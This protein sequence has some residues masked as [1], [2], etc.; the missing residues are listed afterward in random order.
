MTTP[1]VDYTF[2]TGNEYKGN[3]VASADFPRIALRASAIID[4]ITFNRSLPVIE[5]DEDDDTILA[6]QLATCAV[7]DVLGQAELIGGKGEIV[8][9]RVGN[10]SNSYAQT[11]TSK[12]SPQ[13]QQVNAARTY[14]EKTGLMFKGLEATE[15]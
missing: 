6:I 11:Q 8:S 12:L 9:E 2:Y 13:V 15:C 7:A 5:A 14:L 10:V 1:Y 4:R 3:V